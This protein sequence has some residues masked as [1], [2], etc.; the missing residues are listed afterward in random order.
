MV[1]SVRAVSASSRPQNRSCCL[2]VDFA[3]H[4]SLPVVAISEMRAVGKQVYVLIKEAVLLL[5]LL[6]RP[7]R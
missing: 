6:R 7:T 4:L 5:S 1:V 2:E 3:K